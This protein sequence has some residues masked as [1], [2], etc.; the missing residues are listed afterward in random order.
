MEGRS[1]PSRKRHHA[2]EQLWKVGRS[3]VVP[4]GYDWVSQVLETHHRYLLRF[5]GL[6]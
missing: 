4:G 3:E 1:R 5:L 6:V 2:A